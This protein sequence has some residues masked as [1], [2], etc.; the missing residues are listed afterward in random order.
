MV[1]R[2]IEVNHL[3]LYYQ[4]LNINTLS[5]YKAKRNKYL[6]IQGN[7]LTCILEHKDFHVKYSV[8][9][10][11]RPFRVRKLKSGVWT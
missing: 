6:H 3:V 8:A 1:L 11:K 10:A 2:N 9:K 4:R 5:H 7:N